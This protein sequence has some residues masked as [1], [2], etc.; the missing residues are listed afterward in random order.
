M[1]DGQTDHTAVGQV[2]GALH[3]SFSKGTSTDDDTAVL[4]L[5][6]SGENLCGRGGQLVHQNHHLTCGHRATPRSMILLALHFTALS[7]NDEVAILQELIG[8]RHGSLQISAAIILQVEDQPLHTLLLQRFK[9]FHHFLIGSSSEIAE[10]D[11]A[12]TRTDDV[13]RIQTLHGNLI[14]CHDEIDHFGHRTTDN[15]QLNLTSP[16]T[17]ETTHDL[18]T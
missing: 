14:T 13:C 12:D 15:P 2:D 6:S 17:T 7:I 8:N 10:M 1:G 4:I 5:D 18:F 3:Q 16:W 9:R 11:I